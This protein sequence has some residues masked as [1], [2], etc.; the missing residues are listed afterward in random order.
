MAA[1]AADSTSQKP[2]QRPAPEPRGDTLVLV[3]LG[4]PGPRYA[5]TRHNVGFELLDAFALRNRARPFTTEKRF[6]ADVTSVDLDGKRVHLVKPKTFMNNSGASVKAIMSYYKMPQTALMV[7]V[8]DMSLEVGRVRI[9]A[10]GSAGGHNGLKSVQK[11][12]G[13]MEYARLK[14]GVGSPR[15]AGEWSD[16]VLGKL[17]RGELAVLED[18]TWDVMEALEHWVREPDL[19]CV[20]NRMSAAKQA[21]P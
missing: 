15:A 8:D 17:S 5:N 9:R 11:H 14:V 6:Q 19:V 7:V 2:K 4:N 18:V 12:M 21:K 3:G 20:M 10:K 1:T 16:H 13:T